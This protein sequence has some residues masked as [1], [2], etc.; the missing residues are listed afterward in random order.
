MN[1]TDLNIAREKFLYCCK[2]YIKRP[3]LDSLLEYLE[4]KTDFFMPQVQ[5]RI[6]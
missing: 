2:T 5:C 3:G 1:N 6:T 4:Q